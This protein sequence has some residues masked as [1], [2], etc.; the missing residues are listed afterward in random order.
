MSLEHE[1]AASSLVLADQREAIKELKQ[2]VKDYDSYLLFVMPHAYQHWTK[3][4]QLR[5]R[6]REYGI[7]IKEPTVFLP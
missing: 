7:D 3:P 1:L 5:M 6:A 2:L 4:N